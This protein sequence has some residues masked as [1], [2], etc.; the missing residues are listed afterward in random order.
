MAVLP[1]QD[2]LPAYRE[3]ECPLV[4]AMSD[5]DSK[6]RTL[7]TFEAPPS[8]QRMVAI[9]SDGQ[10][11]GMGGDI[12]REIDI[13]QHDQQ[14]STASK[15]IFTRVNSGEESEFR[16]TT[17]EI[18]SGIGST[19][20]SDAGT[21]T[22]VEVQA[23]G[24][25]VPVYIADY[26]EKT[27]YSRG[28]R[29]SLGQE[30]EVEEYRSWREVARRV[31]HRGEKSSSPSRVK[32]LAGRN[33]LRKAARGTKRPALT[34]S[35]VPGGIDSHSARN[36]KGSSLFIRFWNASVRHHHP[37][38]AGYDKVRSTSGASY[39]AGSIRKK[40]SLFSIKTHRDIGCYSPELVSELSRYF[41]SDIVRLQ[42]LG[43]GSKNRKE[44]VVHHPI[45]QFMLDRRHAKEEREI[46]SQGRQLPRTRKSYLSLS[47]PRL[48]SSSQIRIINRHREPWRLL[49]FSKMADTKIGTGELSLAGNVSP[50]LLTNQHVNFATHTRLTVQRF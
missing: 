20:Q 35:K 8:S 42:L 23:M 45:N 16:E 27:N 33:V 10:T 46:K 44:A 40:V 29:N 24:P 31:W 49:E 11:L 5:G 37:S 38:H 2:V 28:S 17:K 30:G 26:K 15:G 14:F 13:V 9:E 25:L 3:L 4:E 48:R 19:D 41:G 43:P 50:W 47:A 1:T 22:P 6:L 12:D 39:L 21:L 32:Q 7:S 18:D 34:A 36:K